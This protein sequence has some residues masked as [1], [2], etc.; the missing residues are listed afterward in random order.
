MARPAEPAGQNSRARPG[1]P[2]RPAPGPAHGV[3]WTP[4]GR[5]TG[6]PCPVPAPPGSGFPSWP[7][8]TREP[9]GMP[10]RAREKMWEELAP[11]RTTRPSASQFGGSVTVMRNDHG[12][13]QSSQPCESYFVRSW[14]NC[15]H[16]LALN[17][18]AEQ[19]STDVFCENQ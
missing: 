15:K 17:T 16:Q 2:S 3:L 6:S 1:P 19:K 5:R 12:V 18:R 14:L 10:V 7:S 11:Y 4:P 9:P 13:T 8:P